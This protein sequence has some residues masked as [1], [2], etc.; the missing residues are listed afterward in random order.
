MTHAPRTYRLGRFRIRSEL[1]LP[2]LAVTEDVGSPR[3]IIRFGSLA[4]ALP[5]PAISRPLYDICRCGT[6]LLRVPGVAR[7][8]LEQDQ[9]TVDPVLPDDAPELALFLMSSVLPLWT[10][11]RGHLCLQAAA[12][13]MNGKAVV[14]C[15]GP[16]SGKST[17]SAWLAKQ[18][19][20]LLSDDIC[21]IDLSGPPC[22]IPTSSGVILGQS[23]LDMLGL[24]ATEGTGI[25]LGPPSVRMRF[26][27]APD[28]IPLSMIAFISQRAGIPGPPP[29]HLS[30]K[31]ALT[32]LTIATAQR[33]VAV[34]LGN[35]GSNFRNAATIANTAPA[36]EMVIPSGLSGLKAA[37]EALWSLR[38]G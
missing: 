16:A 18:G 35:G 12:V 34:G 36:V 20:G 26:Q 8:L 1:R 23:S 25:G 3:L 31:D 6:F 7:Y 5:D 22:V 17:V 30:R 14:L 19:C 13:E 15:G 24:D 38:N 4:E 2:E 28:A 10:A 9:V 21:L 37:G 29:K 32:A 33:T 27:P 11:A